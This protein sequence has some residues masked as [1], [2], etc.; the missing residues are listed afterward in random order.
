M[1]KYLVVICGHLTEG[2]KSQIKEYIN[3][4][5]LDESDI[6]VVSDQDNFKD[7]L[8]EYK[9]YPVEKDDRFELF[10][11]ICL[12]EADYHKIKTEVEH[13]RVYEECFFINTHIEL[14][15]FLPGKFKKTNYRT[16]SLFDHQEYSVRKDYRTEYDKVYHPP[17]LYGK[18]FRNMEYKDDIKVVTQFINIVV[19]TAAFFHC[20]SLEFSNI[21]K[22]Y[23]A[24]EWK[25]LD[26]GKWSARALYPHGTKEVGPYYA[27]PNAVLY[28]LIEKLFFAREY[29]T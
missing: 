24:E 29:V 12:D 27:H 10:P 13:Q 20:R 6:M 19:P 4:L 14:F 28:W 9:F 16:V 5:D 22:Y 15:N 25:E 26:T 2:F 1:N 7:F 3:Y 17:H 23:K 11:F 18:D 8:P 21:A